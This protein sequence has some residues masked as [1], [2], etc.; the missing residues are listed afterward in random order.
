MPRLTGDRIMLREYQKEDLV[1]IRKWCNDPE[2]VEN[3][4]D[5]FLYPHTVNASEGFLNAMI[6]GRDNMKGFVIAH[7]ESE[8]YI[9][10]IDLFDLDW[11]NRSA[12]LGIV[13]GRKE[14]L[15][16]GYGAEAIKLLQHFAFQHM[17]LNRVQLQVYD[18]NKRAYKCYLKCGFREEGRLREKIYKNGRYADTI[19]MSVLKREYGVNRQS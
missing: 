9:G 1:F 5:V 19:C 14:M 3:L 2:I 18:F 6:E 12:E 13:I 4:S 15:G 8:E 17:N 16:K 11:K 7:K 10:Q